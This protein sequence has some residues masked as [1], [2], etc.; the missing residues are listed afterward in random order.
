MRR[1]LPHLPRLRRRW[2]AL[3]PPVPPWYCRLRGGRQARRRTLAAEVARRH[4]SRQP[5]PT[6][7]LTPEP[8][9]GSPVADPRGPGDAEY[10]HRQRAVAAAA[11]VPRAVI[12]VME[13]ITTA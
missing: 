7:G 11:V 5:T 1:S 4:A 9:A 2:L 13:M 12:L 8:V 3:L 10:C 6:Q